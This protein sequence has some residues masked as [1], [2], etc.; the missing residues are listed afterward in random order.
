M[1]RLGQ[2]FVPLPPPLPL[3]SLR[4]ME[5]GLEVVSMVVVVLAMM[6]W[7]Q[8]GRAAGLLASAGDGVAH[9]KSTSTPWGCG[10]GTGRFLCVQPLPSQDRKTAWPW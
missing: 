7:L 1:P 6:A 8:L 2:L 3:Q 9:I 4:V 10:R 5:V